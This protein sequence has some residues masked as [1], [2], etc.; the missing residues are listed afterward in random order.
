MNGIQKTWGLKQYSKLSY[1]Q[2][3]MKDTGSLQQWRDCA[4]FNP[5]LT[6]ASVSQPTFLNFV[7]FLDTRYS[8]PGTKDCMWISGII[9]GT[10]EILIKVSRVRN[11]HVQIDRCARFRSS[12]SCDRII[13][14]EIFAAIH[15]TNLWF[16]INS[17]IRIVYIRQIFVTTYACY[18]FTEDIVT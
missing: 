7:G 9:S 11:E 8:L 16:D 4:P 13:A 15:L 5:A 12:Y 3:I 10:G 1:K 2:F 18:A 17:F 6:T 14:A